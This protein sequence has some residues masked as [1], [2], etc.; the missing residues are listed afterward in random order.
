M[1]MHR[2]VHFFQLAILLMA[3]EHAAGRFLRDD[4][5]EGTKLFWMMQDLVV[6]YGYP[7]D[8]SFVTTEDGYILRMFR[9]R[10]GK[11]GLAQPGSGVVYLQHALLDSSAGFVVMGGN[12]SLAFALADAGFDVWMGNV[13]GNMFSRNHTTF[14]VE[15]ASFW[16][17]SWD[18]FA[19]VDLPAMV[20]HVLE[21]TGASRLQYVG[22]SQG[23]TM[24][25]AAFSS[26]PALAERIELAV[27]LAPVAFLTHMTSLPMLAASEMDTD[28]IFRKLGVHQFLPHTDSLALF[29][30]EVCGGLPEAC[31]LYLSA[32]CGFDLK[33]WDLDVMP[34]IMQYVPAGTSVQNMAHWAQ[35]VRAA[36][37]DQMFYYN[38]GNKCD[39]ADGNPLPCNRRKYGQETPPVYALD[40]ITIPLA[41]FTGSRDSL[42]VPRDVSLLV[43]K[44]QPGVVVAHHD[45][46][47]YAHLDFE[48]G[49]DIGERLFPLILNVLLNKHKPRNFVGEAVDKLTTAHLV[50][51]YN[52]GFLPTASA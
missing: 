1:G 18:Q 26:Q 22:Y 9:I 35:G 43:S 52:G 37:E 45:F 4:P 42:S 21:K 40:Q 30:G 49:R 13:R 51:G 23:T 15:D 24:A 11:A 20:N 16:Q 29:W 34:L 8:E 48:L 5:A 14:L 25:F 6:P 39:D 28:A 7:L 38:W 32:I 44:L 50:S 27:L 10:H 31:A 46:P 2:A 17:F 41:L 36:V 12:R 33:N 47:D 3:G 19:A